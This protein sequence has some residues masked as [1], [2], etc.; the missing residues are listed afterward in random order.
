MRSSK[1]RSRNK[2]N[3]QRSLGN[4]VNRVFDSSGPEGKVR[5]TPQQIIEKY[6]AL[7]R[8]AQL[9]NDRVAEQS[10]FQH[11][12]H[13]TRLLGEAQREMAERQSQQQQHQRH[14][15][16]EGQS[17]NGRDNNG[18]RDNGNRDH[19][20]HQPRTQPELP[21]ARESDDVATSAAQPLPIA[22]PAPVEEPAAVE[23]AAEPQPDT[24]ALP[25]AVGAGAEEMSDR[26]STPE[27]EEKPA[28]RARTPRPRAPRAA[29]P[30]TRKKADA[31][32]QLADAAPTPESGSE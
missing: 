7:A 26:V 23:T 30:R 25:D 21:T 32:A 9:S 22:E 27:T 18:N 20:R 3:R 13:Y 15:E 1:S 5:G 24:P 14:G 4:V 8:D 2:S 29:T 16:D 19:G 28:P 12:E 11:A 17:G 31:D 6:L 10:F